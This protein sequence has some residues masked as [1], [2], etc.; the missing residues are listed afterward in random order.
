MRMNRQTIIP[1]AVLLAVLIGLLFMWIPAQ[2]SPRSLSVNPPGGSQPATS[3]PPP[4]PTLTITP[5]PMT[6]PDHVTLPEML[7]VYKEVLQTNKDVTGWLLG[8]LGASG[9]GGFFLLQRSLKS[10]DELKTR[11]DQIRF[12]L[13]TSK[14]QIGDFEQELE[15]HQQ[16]A[17]AVKQELDA[18][19]KQTEE[20]R[21]S[22]EE[23]QD[24]L[25]AQSKE[26]DDI[27]RQ[28]K[29]ANRDIQARIPR[30]EKLAEVDT[31]AMQM[32]SVTRKSR[33]AA[34]SK[35]LQYCLD[36]DDSVV[37]RECIRVFG[38]IPDYPG[39]FDLQD[40]AILNQLR[41]L[42]LRDKERGV[43]LEAIQALKKFGVD[44][45]TEEPI[46]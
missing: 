1:A 12:E 43:R 33:Q 25:T 6:T 27:R 30:L 26:M 38:A 17:A 10:I 45:D 35:L 4:T 32:F 16:Q 34:R 14:R 20:L 40:E 24:R 2:A 3:T 5:S 15:K 18:R 41:E 36:E 13:D 42:A 21:H 23:L 46:A 22:N 9:V 31:A 39:H 29:L 7:S 11:S 28:A 8:I 19:I 37:R 44:L